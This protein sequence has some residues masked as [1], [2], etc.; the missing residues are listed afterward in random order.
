M[1]VEP[2]SESS[3]SSSLQTVTCEWSLGQP[4]MLICT[5][6]ILGTIQAKHPK[7]R[8]LIGGY[9]KTP[10]ILGQARSHDFKLVDNLK[11]FSD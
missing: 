8:Q 2:E 5:H 6:P 4:A 9:K 1:E 11:H 3:E 7:A 10:H